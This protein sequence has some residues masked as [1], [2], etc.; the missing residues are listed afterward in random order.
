[1]REVAGDGAALPKTRSERK[2]CSCEWCGSGL[3]AARANKR[4]CSARCRRDA[5][6]ERAHKGRVAAVRRLKDG[7]MSVTLHMPD[8][9]LR[10]GDNVRVSERMVK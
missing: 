2:A 5:W 7:R 9:G 10:P 8:I 3:T 6:A 4:F 1:L